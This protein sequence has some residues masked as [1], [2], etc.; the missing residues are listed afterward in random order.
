[1]HLTPT[2]SKL[3][4]LLEHLYLTHMKFM[5][6]TG[7][8]SKTSSQTN[9]L[10]TW[11]HQKEIK[12]IKPAFLGN[13]KSIRCIEE[14]QVKCPLPQVSG[15]FWRADACSVTSETN[16]PSCRMPNLRHWNT[17]RSIT[18]R[19]LQISIA[20][21]AHYT[22]HAVQRSLEWRFAVNAR[23]N[24]RYHNRNAKAPHH[25]GSGLPTARNPTPQFRFA[26]PPGSALVAKR[27][28]VWHLRD[29]QPRR[30]G[31]LFLV[32]LRRARRRAP[33]LLVPNKDEPAR[34]CRQLHV[35]VK[36][37]WFLSKSC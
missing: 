22:S 14:L 4:S 32:Q 10:T 34:I 37:F 19:Q 33:S 5:F 12:P 27:R 29:R 2:A 20:H 16:F 9:K 3:Q 21:T 13:S 18:A 24:R 36:Q 35:Q 31:R 26:V 11:K 8:T 23:Q 28:R 1:M 17:Q 30:R 7:Q 15:N 25:H 6:S